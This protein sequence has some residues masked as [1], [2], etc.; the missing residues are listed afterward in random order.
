MDQQ[1][2]DRL[3]E[4]EKRQVDAKRAARAKR[5]GARPVDDWRTKRPNTPKEVENDS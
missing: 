2:Y 1:A 4:E 5:R 3:S